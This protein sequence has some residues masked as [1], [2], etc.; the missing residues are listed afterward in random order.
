MNQKTISRTILICTILSGIILGA[1][2]PAAPQPTAA[3]TEPVS[4]TTDM[5][6]IQT[7]AVQTVYAA[8]TET[9]LA[10]PTETMVLPSATPMEGIFSTNTPINTLTPVP[11]VPPEA[12]VEWLPTWTPELTSTPIN[13]ELRCAILSQTIADSQV[14]FPGES[15]E[16][17][18]TIE[19]RGTGYW[20]S[21]GI[22]IV[23]VS[24]TEMET[25]GKR[26]DLPQDV[27]PTGNFS[28]SISMEAPSNPGTY[29]TTWTFMGDPGTFC[30]LT[31]RIKVE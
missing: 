22:D 20:N 28:F 1:C 2:V 11:V 26:I 14:M 21:A 4:P 3:P 10:Q 25:G 19:N 12:T 24:G 17:G 8:L 5:S 31:V 6:V 30:P 13:K 9:A 23:Y 16:A 7:N 18:W 15:F 29:Q 27:P